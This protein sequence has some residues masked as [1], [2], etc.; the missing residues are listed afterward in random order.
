MGTEIQ[1]LDT[2]LDLTLVPVM[3]W[4][5]SEIILKGR[6][7]VE[8]C[9]KVVLTREFSIIS[10]GDF[11]II[12]SW[13]DPVC[14]LFSDRTRLKTK[15]FSFLWIP[16]YKGLGLVYTKNDVSK[17]LSPLQSTQWSPSSLKNTCLIVSRVH[18]RL[19]L[20]RTRTE[21]LLIVDF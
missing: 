3:R 17:S 20:I 8:I 6:T 13:S 4:L 2:C 9:T 5:G 12:W 18:C 16:C 15:Y 11:W 14:Q 10:V 19:G 21:I 7:Q 1:R